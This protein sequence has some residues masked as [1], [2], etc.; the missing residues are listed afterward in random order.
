MKDGFPG[1]FSGRVGFALLLLGALGLSI[2]HQ[3]ARPRR[4]VT[5]TSHPVPLSARDPGLDRVGGLKYLSGLVLESSDPGFGGLSG[6]TVVAQGD[7]LELL[8]VTDQGDRFSAQLRTSSRQMIGLQA[9]ALEP[10]VGEDGRPLASKEF[11]DAESM[12]P[13]KDGSFLVGFERRHRILSYGP[14]LRGP[15]RQV[16][17]PSRL[18]EAPSNGG[19]ESLAQW[20]D[21]RLLVITESMP[22]PDGL[23]TG[24]ILHDGAWSPLAW[25]PS[26]PGFEPADATVLPNGNLL[27]LERFWSALSPLNIR[28]RITRVPGE[29]VKP[30]ARLRGDVLAEL[31]S[32]LL[33][34]N[35]EG[36]SALGKTFSTQIFLISDNNFSRAQ[37]TL[38][39]WFELLD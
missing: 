18:R 1:S 29:A 32:P 24:Y 6:L 23:T 35:F 37:R 20:P 31:S 8:A 12:V 3:T 17:I 14:G 15:A 2:A 4:E 22:R 33:A 9:A 34:E 30:G 19:I 16:D 38:L 26:A 36:I 28:T 13:R 11:G 25:T 39:L 10:L 21:G 7:E 5:L 27:I